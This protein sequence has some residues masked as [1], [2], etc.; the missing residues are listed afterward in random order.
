MLPVTSDFSYP[1]REC[2]VDIMMWSGEAWGIDGGKN[3]DAREDRDDK[4]SPKAEQR[5]RKTMD[6]CRTKGDTDK[7]IKFLQEVLHEVKQEEFKRSEALQEVFR[8][9]PELYLIEKKMELNRLRSNSVAIPSL[10]SQLEVFKELIESE[11]AW[12]HKT[13]QKNDG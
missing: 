7:Q 13:G 8:E 1:V 2:I 11:L 10:K 4:G 6:L 5:F 9:S 12:R 3:M